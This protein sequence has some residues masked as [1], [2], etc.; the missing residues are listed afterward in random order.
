[1]ATIS[2]SKEAQM[3]QKAILKYLNSSKLPTTD[4]N[5]GP[6]MAIAILSLTDCVNQFGDDETRQV[7][8]EAALNFIEEF[9]TDSPLA[10][11]SIMKMSK[12]DYMIIPDRREEQA[13]QKKEARQKEHAYRNQL[14][15]R[16]EAKNKVSLQQM[17]S[18]VE[19]MCGRFVKLSRCSPPHRSR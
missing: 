13:R 16:R 19:L 14:A 10:T 8:Q 11:P 12:M 6:S 15:A 2:L 17:S 4:P 7:S 3:T 18:R 9:G 5:R 1:M